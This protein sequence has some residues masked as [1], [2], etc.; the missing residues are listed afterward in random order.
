MLSTA[1]YNIAFYLGPCEKVTLSPPYQKMPCL[2]RSGLYLSWTWKLNLYLYLSLSLPLS[3]LP[4]F[5]PPSF[6]F[7]PPFFCQEDQRKT[8]DTDLLIQYAFS[9]IFSSNFVFFISCQASIFSFSCI[10]DTIWTLSCFKLVLETFIVHI[11]TYLLTILY[12][13]LPTCPTTFKISVYSPLVFTQLQQGFH[14]VIASQYNIH[15]HNIIRF[16]NA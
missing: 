14:I 11:K 7:C 15:I 1:S 5:F 9:I 3:F 6:P 8:C 10:L 13:F 2:G 16:T 12:R 4:P